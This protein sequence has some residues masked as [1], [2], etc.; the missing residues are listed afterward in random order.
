MFCE[1]CNNYKMPDLSKDTFT[2]VAWIHTI[3]RDEMTRVRVLSDILYIYIYVF[4]GKF[5]FLS[6][7]HEHM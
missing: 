3:V 7:I 2:N 1:E 4:F 6:H 5:F